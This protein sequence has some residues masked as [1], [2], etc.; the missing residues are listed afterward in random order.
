MKSHPVT[1]D[2]ITWQHDNTRPHIKQCV[3]DFFNNRSV[4]LLYQAPY[5][6]D[7]NL[8]DRW[9]N[10]H[11]KTTLRKEIFA[12]APEVEKRVTELM[13]DIDESVYRKEVDKLMKHCGDVIAAGGEYV[14]PI[15]SYAFFL[16]FYLNRCY[17]VCFY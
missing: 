3:K 5:S 6:P 15:L 8:C 9:L 16:L 17:I 4:N 11:L 10:N 12:S 14:T 2:K 13:R 7:L 1:M